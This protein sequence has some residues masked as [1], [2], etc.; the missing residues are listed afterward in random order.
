MHHP[1]DRIAYTTTFVTLVVDHWLE[2]DIYFS[3]NS[4]IY[5]P[6]SSLHAFQCEK[7]RDVAPS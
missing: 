7:E 5:T 3:F 1:I 2:R 6:L 4:R